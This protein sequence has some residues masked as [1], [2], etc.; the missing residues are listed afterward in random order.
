MLLLPPLLPPPLPLLLLLLLASF[1]APAPAGEM[2]SL[3]A[4]FD[5]LL[6]LVVVVVVVPGAG[7]PRLGASPTAGP[8]AATAMGAFAGAFFF[9]PICG[10]L[11][12]AFGTAAGC[13]ALALDTGA[14]ARSAQSPAAVSL[15]SA[16]RPAT[17]RARSTKHEAT[18]LAEAGALLP[19]DATALLLSSL[20]PQPLLLLP[21]PS[22]SSFLATGRR[23]VLGR[24]SV[25]SSAT[26]FPV[27]KRGRGRWCALLRPPWPRACTPLA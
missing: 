15:G 8:G 12:G 16:P 22:W 10:C 6:F 4:R 13:L 20:L 7:A 24:G 14:G 2:I 23:A 25:C 21:Q 17:T 11:G 19:L 26:P 1:S 27:K 18:T 9:A 5:C 3:R